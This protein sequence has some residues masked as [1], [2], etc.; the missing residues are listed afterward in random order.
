MTDASFPARRTALPQHLAAIEVNL[1]R[2]ARTRAVYTLIGLAAVVLILFSGITVANDVN[3]G[4]FS[5]GISSVFDYPADMI[6]GAIAAGW[7]WWPILAEYVPDLIATLNMAIFATATGFVLATVLSLFASNNLVSNRLV[8]TLSRRAFDVFRSFPELVIAMIL[9]YLM[10]QSPLPAVIAI[11]IHTTGA[12]GKLFS[13][14]IE[15]SDPKPL[16][17][18]ASVGA[19]WFARVR[20]GVLTQVIPLFVSYALL[21]LEINVRASTILGFVGAGGI[22]EALNTVIQWRR[23]PDV[24]A[25]IVLLIATITALDYLSDYVRNR[26]IGY[27]V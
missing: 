7:G 1:A 22:G 3:A 24:C 8:V 13:E 12:L 23:G 21:R 20:F 5:R 11:T 25:I 15:N 10:G 16:E 9:L 18:L 26:F 14:A 4:S 19:P 6:G 17:G 2:M 27:R